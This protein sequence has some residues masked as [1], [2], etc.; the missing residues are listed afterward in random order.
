MDQRNLD[1][2]L[3]VGFNDNFQY[4]S[5][6][7]SVIRIFDINQRLLEMEQTQAIPDEEALQ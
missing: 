6:Y 1:F 4:H 7:L 3:N 2:P 5:L